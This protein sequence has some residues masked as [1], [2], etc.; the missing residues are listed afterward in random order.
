MDSNN[1]LCIIYFFTMQWLFSGLFIS[2]MFCFFCFYSL[3]TLL[4]HGCSFTYFTLTAKHTTIE[5]K[6]L[7]G[8]R[9][10]YI[11]SCPEFKFQFWIQVIEKYYRHQFRNSTQYT[12]CN[13]S[14]KLNWIIHSVLSLKENSMFSNWKQLKY[15]WSLPETKEIFSFN[16][17]F[18][19][20]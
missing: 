20:G 19:N 8:K 7:V 16:T 2:P 18:P 10:T 12:T 13:T 5:L 1:A 15:D 4:F 3:S 11:C 14:K 6:M 17:I 9:I